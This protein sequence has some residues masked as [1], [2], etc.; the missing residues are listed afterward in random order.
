MTMRPHAH[1]GLLRRRMLTLGV[2][3]GGLLLFSC[4]GHESASPAPASGQASR[5][6]EPNRL[7]MA[8]TMTG[9]GWRFSGLLIRHDKGKGRL[10]FLLLLRA[11]PAHT[12]DRASPA[13]LDALLL[14]ETGIQLC[15]M[16]LGPESTDMI[17]ALP[18][19]ADDV[20]RAA[21]PAIRTLV[22][23]PQPA[24]DGRIEPG[25]KGPELHSGTGLVF[26][27]SDGILVE[28]E[29]R[30]AGTWFASYGDHTLDGGF[31]LPGFLRYKDN[32]LELRL[33]RLMPGAL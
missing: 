23:A 11:V 3:L 14:T 28:K 2:L 4:A 19:G 8:L 6:T 27:F 33:V 21:G 9:E 31:W 24:L 15:A 30:A 1:P 32:R 20:C 18:G 12:A 7:D 10:P 17:Q 26:R 22:L 29:S 5:L 13:A 16:R 25:R